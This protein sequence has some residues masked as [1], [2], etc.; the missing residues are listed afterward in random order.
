[1]MIYRKLE[2]EFLK[3][4]LKYNFNNNL[5]GFL[6]FSIL[7]F[8]VLG[9]V[10]LSYINTNWHISLCI[11]IVLILFLVCGLILMMI[12]YPRFL[13]YKEIK[14]KT[15]KISK[16]SYKNFRTLLFE[17]SKEQLIDYLYQE[18]LNQKTKVALLINHYESLKVVKANFSFPLLIMLSLISSII[19]SL[20]ALPLK[21][22]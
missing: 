14:K 6:L 21:K 8:I 1:M 22:E 16:F 9:V 13:Y 10:S 18:N 17:L 2:N 5:Q 12:I 15:E 19:L 3:S 20:Y 11:G 7:V 4:T